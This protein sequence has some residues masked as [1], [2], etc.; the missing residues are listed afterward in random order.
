M[1]SSGLHLTLTFFPKRSLQVTSNIMAV[2]AV[3]A[4]VE[5]EGVTEGEWVV[6]WEAVLEAVLG[7]G[8]EEDSARWLVEVFR[9]MCANP[10]DSREHLTAQNSSAYFGGDCEG[11]KPGDGAP[12]IVQCLEQ[13][14]EKLCSGS[15]GQRDLRPRSH[16]G[17]TMVKNMLMTPIL[18][19]QKMQLILWMQKMQLLGN[20]LL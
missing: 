6:E 5:G 20:D 11:R 8:Q 2:V 3:E 7:E 18:W 17:L 16:R 12:I 14:L 13:D 15:V 1:V 19:M 4:V 9:L 10:E